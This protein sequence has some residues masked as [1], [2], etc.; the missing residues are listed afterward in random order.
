MSRYKD[1]PEFGI[2]G[3]ISAFKMSCNLSDVILRKDSRPDKRRVTRRGNGQH[4][5]SA[6]SV[7]RA[8]PLSTPRGAA[9]SV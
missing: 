6:A 7:E 4:G 8:A 1:K 5:T 2:P 3:F 9:R